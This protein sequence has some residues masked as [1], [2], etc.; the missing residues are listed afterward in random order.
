M[1]MDFEG[2]VAWVSGAA[3]KPGMG[4]AVARILARHGADVACVDVVVPEPTAADTYEASPEGL[5]AVVAAVEAEGRRALGLAIDPT[6]PD[7]VAASVARTVETLGRVDLCANLSGGTGPRFGTGPLLDVSPQ[8][9]QRTLDANLTATWLGAQACARQMIA[10]GDGGA[11][12]NLA[13]SAALTGEPSF[14]AFSAARAGVVRMTEVLAY[15]LAAHNIR[16]NSVCPLGVAPAAGG[17][18]PGLEFT[19]MQHKGDVDAWVRDLIPLGR[20]QSPEETANVMVFLLSDA[21]SFVT[22]ENVQVTGGA[23]F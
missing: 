19:A 8:I 4:A 16:A 3:R 22:G 6:D 15:E 23:R 9:W 11:I 12:V 5:A 10:Q 1:M 17:G 14:G 2:K 20:M 7:E 21:A 13:S 18:N